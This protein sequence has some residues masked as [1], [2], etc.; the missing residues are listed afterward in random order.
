MKLSL[1]LSSMEYLRWSALMFSIWRRYWKRAK[2]SR[3][4]C[5]VCYLI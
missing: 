5:G 4:N 3:W 1:R 2:R